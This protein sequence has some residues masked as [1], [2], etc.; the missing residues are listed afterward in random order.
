MMERLHRTLHTGLSHIV[1]SANNTWDVLV[2]FFLM[3]YR[4]TTNTTTKYR[5]FYLLHGIETPLPT[6]EN[7]KAKISKENPSQSNGLKI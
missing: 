4:A 5:R 3:A 7:L 2:P 1:N 6:N